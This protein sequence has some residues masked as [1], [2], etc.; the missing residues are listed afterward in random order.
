MLN[1]MQFI[2][3]IQKGGRIPQAVGAGGG[4]GMTPVTGRKPITG[5][6]MAKKRLETMLR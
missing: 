6:E 1:P 2:Q 4:D 3:A 5:M